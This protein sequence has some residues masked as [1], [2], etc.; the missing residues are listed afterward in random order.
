VTDEELFELVRSNYVEANRDYLVQQMKEAM[1]YMPRRKKL[2]KK[3]YMKYLLKRR[4]ERKY[5]TVDFSLLRLDD[6]YRIVELIKRGGPNWFKKENK[7]E[8]NNS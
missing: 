7:N 2:R 4:N 8:H 5:I 1:K 6:W 3:T